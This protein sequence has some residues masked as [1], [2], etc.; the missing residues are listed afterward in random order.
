MTGLESKLRELP[1]YL[2][3]AYIANLHEI[4]ALQKRGED[5]R[6]ELKLDPL[7]EHNAIT[8]EMH[9]VEHECLKHLI[10]DLKSTDA[11]VRLNA[12]KWLCRQEWGKDFRASPYEQRYWVGHDTTDTKKSG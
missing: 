9:Q 11:K 8:R 7:R 6:R 3:Q 10:P 1:G 4:R 12:Y 5:L 2:Q